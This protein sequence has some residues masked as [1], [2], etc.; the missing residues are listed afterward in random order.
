MASWIRKLNWNFL[1]FL[2]IIPGLTPFTPPHLFEKLDLV[3]QG[4]LIRPIDWFDLIFHGLPWCLAFVK[5]CLQAQKKF[6]NRIKNSPG[7]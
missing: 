6:S 7:P 1:I 5:I 4:R 3:F 2:C